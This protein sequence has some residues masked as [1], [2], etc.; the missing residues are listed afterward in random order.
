MACAGRTLWE[1]TTVAPTVFHGQQDL[2]SVRLEPYAKE[3]CQLIPVPAYLTHRVHMFIYGQA[4]RG[5]LA[6]GWDMVHCWDEP[7]ILAGGQV[8][9]WTPRGT[10]LVYRTAQSLNKRYPMPF[11][12]IERYAMNRASGWICSGRLVAQALGTRQGYS[13]RPMAM[14]PL[15][16]DVDSFRPDPVAGQAIRQSLGWA[17]RRLPVIGY[18]GRFVPEKGLELL[19]RVL[20]QLQVPWRALF[21]G[22]GPLEPLLRAWAERHRDHVRFCTDVK[23]DQVP[24]YLNAMDVLCAPSQTSPHWREQ[25]G[26]MIIEAFACGVPFIGSDS[27]EIPFVVGDDGVIVGEKDQAGWCSVLTEL[28]QDPARRQELTVRGLERARTE[29]AWH[30]VAK[31]YLDFFAEL[32]DGQAGMHQGTSGTALR[33]AIP[34]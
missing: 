22:A 1:V 31:R 28:L 33:S 25:F 2:R 32:L 27:G 5:L 13:N 29:Y 16:V 10:P 8:A 15:G 30:V 7:Y 23:H 26:R 21:V 12:W 20:D 14:I 6:Q 11:N 17:E 34:A 3:L 24:R 18:L 9:W 4:L 19:M